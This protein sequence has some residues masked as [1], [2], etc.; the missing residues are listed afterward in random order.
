MQDYEHLLLSWT[1]LQAIRL[2]MGENAEAGSMRVIEQKLKEEYQITEVS[3]VGRTLDEYAVSFRK[4]GENK[5]V[6]FDAD[7]VESIYDV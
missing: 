4:N 7:E 6:R 5:M 1:Q 3:L 2:I